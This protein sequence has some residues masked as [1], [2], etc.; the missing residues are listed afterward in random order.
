[1]YI[2][3]N[4]WLKCLLLCCTIGL[5]ILF[6]IYYAKEDGRRVLGIPVVTEKEVQNLTEG[7][8]RKEEWINIL[9]IKDI[10]HL[11]AT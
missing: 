8:K 3:K 4:Y 5:L 7:R 2:K 6:L 11:S 1:M 9:G 10:L